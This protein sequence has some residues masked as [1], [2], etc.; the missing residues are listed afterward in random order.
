MLWDLWDRSSTCCLSPDDFPMPIDLITGPLDRC[1]GGHFALTP[2]ELATSSAPG[3]NEA[4]EG[5]T[6]VP[7]Q[8]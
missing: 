7:N 4:D 2:S 5:T 8:G 6:V 3:S 1:C